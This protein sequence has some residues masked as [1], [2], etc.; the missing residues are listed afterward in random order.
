MQI[1]TSSTKLETSPENFKG[2]NG[3]EVYLSGKFYKYTYGKC[4]S[5]L[6]AK[7]LLE[8]VNE[9]GYNTSFVTAFED[10]KRIDLKQAIDK[11]E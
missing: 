7:E 3:V 10:G 5:F 1:A 9:K 2:L 6:E 4:K 11:T 8:E